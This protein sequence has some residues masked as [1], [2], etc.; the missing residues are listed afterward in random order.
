MKY[1]IT[2]L[3][4]FCFLSVVA[5]QETTPPPAPTVGTFSVAANAIALP[6]KNNSTLAAAMTGVTLQVTPNFNL[7]QTNFVS[8]GAETNAYFGGFD[9]TIP[10]FSKWLNDISPNLNGYDF[11]LQ[12]TA[13][14]GASRIA[15][16]TTNDVIQHYA[17]LVGGRLQYAIKGSSTYS[18]VLELDDFNSPGLAKRNNLVV[19]AGPVIHFGR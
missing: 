6:G 9:Y 5:A 18:L 15:N 11:K 1:V 17:F 12:A 13:S 19:A 7:R 10:K 4:Y 8:S 3:L 2:S 16:P 14:V